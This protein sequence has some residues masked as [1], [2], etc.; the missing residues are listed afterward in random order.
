MIND[1]LFLEKCLSTYSNT[2]QVKYDPRS[3]QQST[4]TYNIQQSGTTC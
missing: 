1:L 2:I 4:R 3:T